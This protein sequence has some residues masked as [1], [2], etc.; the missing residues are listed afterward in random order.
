M[1]FQYHARSVHAGTKT[2]EITSIRDIE[3]VEKTP[4]QELGLPA[5]VY[6]AVS[7]AADLYPDAIAIHHVP[8]V[9]IKGEVISI[10]YSQLKDTNYPRCQFV[11]S[12]RRQTRRCGFIID[13]GYS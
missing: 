6:Q 12:F 4:W 1:I 9:D 5:T 11:S 2:M 10:S 13:A 8:E 3:R 7:R